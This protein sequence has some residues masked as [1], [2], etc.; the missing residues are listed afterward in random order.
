MIDPDPSSVINPERTV[1]GAPAPHR[2]VAALVVAMSASAQ[3]VDKKT[4]SFEAATKIATKA[5]DEARARGVGVVIAIVDDGGYLIL[6]H[7]LNDT[8]FPVTFQ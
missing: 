1:L 6:L 2:T 3:T 8:Q 5:A 4:L 7:R